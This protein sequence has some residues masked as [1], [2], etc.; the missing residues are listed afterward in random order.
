MVPVLWRKLGRDLWALRGQVLAIALVLGSGLAVLIMSLGA[1]RA[2]EDTRDAFYDRARFADVFAEVRRAPQ[3][4]AAGLARIPGVRAV[5]T[6]VR[7]RALLD[8]PGLDEPGSAVVLS[9]PE[10]GRPRLNDLVLREGRWPRRSAPD[11]VLLGEAFAEAHGLRPGDHLTVLLRGTRRTLDVAGIALSPEFV[12]TLPPGAL[13]PDDRRNGVLWM[14]REALA[15]ASGQ[16]GAFNSVVLSLTRS[17]RE[18]AVLAEVDALLDRY[19][20]TGA[21]PRR[22][23]TSDWFLNG[24]IDQLATLAVVLPS[25]FLGVAAFLINIAAN[26]L[27]AL[28]QPHVG[29]LKAFG[30]TNAQVA[31]HYLALMLAMAVPGV[32]LGWLGGAALGR[33]VTELYAQ[34][35]RFPF[36]I[37]RPDA[38]VFVL[39]A[40]IGFGAAAVGALAAVRRAVALHPAEAMVPPAPP[41]YRR[42]VVARL[43]PAGTLDQPTM[44]ILRHIARWPVRAGL[45]TA[46][47]ALACAVLVLSLHW[48]PSIDALLERQFF[49]ENRQDA[50]VTFLEPRPLRVAEDIAHLPGVLAVEPFR[51]VPVIFRAGVRERREALTALP[52]TPGL[53]RPLDSAGVPLRP[54][55]KGLMLTRTL[56]DLLGVGLG[57]VVT[58]EVREGRRPTLRLPVVALAETHIGL[59]AWMDR[60][61]LWAALGEAPSASGAYVALD[62]ARE[63][64]FTAALKETP[65]VAGVMLRATAVGTFRATMAETMMIMVGFYVTF[66]GLLTFG[67]VY[68][69]ARVA[70]SERG[71]ELA[72]LRVLGFTEGEVTYILLGELAV[73]TLAALPLGAGAGWLLA[74]GMAQAMGT[75]LYRIPA[76]VTPAVAGW[77]MLTVAG[78]SVLSALLVA[79]RVRRLDLVAVLKTRE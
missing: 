41:V 66:A 34:F 47:I 1:I 31:G 23:Q 5:E 8:L 75:E 14:G 26:R 35:F 61:A 49:R 43:L 3:A 4:V 64:A 79:R 63:G 53:A 39:A 38:G 60:Q 71:R 32:L 69:S 74:Q 67:V 15:A 42:S 45:T 20:G 33:W 7:E 21:Y 22:D 72:S 68:N 37:Y 18:A 70:L 56:A 78:A 46:G 12:Y 44:M 29:L 58:V 9:V 52:P 76:V 51:A 62:P 30:F 55:P 77:A 65:M 17:A 6:R 48:L 59:G 19:G 11:E 24:E 28:E 50:T 16:E 2:L 27:I 54:P 25:I 57:D 10:D 40:A 13:M 36:L 73:L